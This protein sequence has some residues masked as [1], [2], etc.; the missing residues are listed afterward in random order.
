MR[1]FFGSMVLV[2]RS[3]RYA[4]KLSVM[5]PFLLKPAALLKNPAKVKY[6]AAMSSLCRAGVS[7]SVGGC[8]CGGCGW[9][10]V[11]RGFFG[12][13]WFIDDVAFL[14]EDSITNKSGSQRRF[15]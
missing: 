9:V 15:L 4:G 11:R 8:W 1:A 3:S 5:G 14:F 13:T 7:D 10:M 12:S 6:M 2:V